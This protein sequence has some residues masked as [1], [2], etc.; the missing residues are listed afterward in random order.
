MAK[1]SQRMLALGEERSEIREI[2]EFGRKRTAEGAEVLDFSLGNPSV[3]TPPAV[4]QELLRLLTEQNGLHSYTSAQGAPETRKALAD[5]LNRR[6]G[7]NYD[8]DCF[9]LTAGAAAALVCCLS[10]ICN[11]GDEVITFAP[12][13][14][15]YT[16]F[17]SQSGA[18]LKVVPAETEGFQIDFA[19]F[20]A[21][22]SPKTRAVLIN[23]PNNPSGAVYSEDTIQRLSALLRQKSEEYGAA[24]TLISDEP[25]REIC[26]DQD[27]IPFVPNYYENTIVCYSYSKSLS[28]PGARIGYVLVPKSA[29]DHARLY[30]AIC[31]AGRSLGYV[32]APSHMQH[33][34]QSCAGETADLTV[35]RQNRDLLVSALS[36]MGYTVPVPGG[37]FYLFFAAP[38]GDAAGF[39][40]RAQEHDVLLVPGD[41]FG[42]ATHVR[43]AYCVPTER[44]E[45]A[46]P[47]FRALI[48]SYRSTP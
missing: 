20:E 31:G 14:P 37:A 41:S 11:P 42:C 32:C 23:S 30:A 35:Y 12:F 27:A 1:L 44:I 36:E 16:V 21:L 10:A 4:E 19:A 24:I 7:T 18:T 15:E 13:F 48:D 28:L 26:Y 22:L 33:M 46:L 8:A 29:E 34:L 40:R 43:L 47:R 3:P 2:F 17:V 39:C 45:R 25:Y 5:D 9:Y 38:D 6:F